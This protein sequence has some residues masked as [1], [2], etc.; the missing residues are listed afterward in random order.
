MSQEQ[1]KSD[2]VQLERELMRRIDENPGSPLLTEFLNRLPSEDR[3][4]LL[5]GEW[6]VSGN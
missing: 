6:Q 3:E 4:R 2:L 5:R 1:Q